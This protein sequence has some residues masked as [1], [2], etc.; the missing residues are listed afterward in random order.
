VQFD[1]GEGPSSDV[2]T[3]DDYVRVDDLADDRLAALGNP[4]AYQRVFR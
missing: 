3:T 1:A 4:S 2:L